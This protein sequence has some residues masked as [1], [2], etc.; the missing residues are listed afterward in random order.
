[1]TAPVAPRPRCDD[2]PDAQRAAA[3]SAH[4]PVVAL[5]VD[6]STT[7]PVAARWAATVARATGR[8]LLA[9]VPHVDG[10]DPGDSSALA[11]RVE[12][13]LRSTGREVAFVRCTVP[14]QDRHGDRAAAALRSALSAADVALLVCVA[15]PRLPALVA[16][17]LAAPP[18]DLLLVPDGARPGRPTGAH[19]GPP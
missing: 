18:V 15:G 16:E 11:A 19:G 12:P 3:V 4:R 2:R 5:L 6:G 8:G 17:L 14:A 1:M 10:T 13:A 7:A 9:V